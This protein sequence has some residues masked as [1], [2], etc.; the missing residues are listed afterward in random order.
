[1]KNGTGAGGACQ[2]VEAGWLTHCG[3]EACSPSGGHTEHTH[4][5][6]ERHK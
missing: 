6:R 1:M 5:P 4:R 2:R 3:A